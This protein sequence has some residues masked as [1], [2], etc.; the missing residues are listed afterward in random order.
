MKLLRKATSIFDGTINL[1]ALLAAVI[2]IF[3]TFSILYEIV[4]RYFLNRPTLWVQEYTEFSLVFITFLGA[5][6]LLKREGHVRLDVVLTRLTPRTQTVVNI[7]TSILGAITFLIVAWYGV[8]ATW[9]SFVAGARSSAI[10]KVPVFLILFII[11]V[12]S[13]LFSI[14]FL[15]MAYGFFK[16]GR[17]APDKE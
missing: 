6:W 3:V 16:K 8:D 15:R 12:G 2:L 10:V 1:I 17:V 13:F 7:I 4:M 11:P 5:T 14:Q 9:N